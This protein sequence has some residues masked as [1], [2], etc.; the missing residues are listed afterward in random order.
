MQHGIAEQTLFTLPLTPHFSGLVWVRIL[1]LAFTR[2]L[3]LGKP[4]EFSV[5]GEGRVHWVL[6]F[7]YS[8]IVAI[9]LAH[10]LC[11]VDLGTFLGLMFSAFNLLPKPHVQVH[12]YSCRLPDSCG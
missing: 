9:C 1:A 12:W 2:Y 10:G 7:L 11:A 4:L 5:S 8:H 3:T 6:P